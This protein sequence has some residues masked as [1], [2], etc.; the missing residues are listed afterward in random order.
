M[1]TKSRGEYTITIKHT[2]TICPHHPGAP[3]QRTIF[4]SD[5]CTKVYEGC[6]ICKENVHAQY[7]VRHPGTVVE[8]F[9]HNKNCYKVKLGNEH[10]D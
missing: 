1:K 4:T 6:E 9:D 7:S 8:W 3:V 10:Y 2:R 5:V